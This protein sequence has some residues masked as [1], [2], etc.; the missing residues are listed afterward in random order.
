MTDIRKKIAFLTFGY[1]QDVPGSATRTA[2]DAH[3]QTLDLAQAAED[4][5]VDGAFLRVHHWARQL[6]SPFPLLA[7]IA[8][9]TRRI[10]IGT[11]VINMRYENPLYMAEE[12][13]AVDLISGGRLQLGISRGAPDSVSD[14]P[15]AFGY[16]PAGGE[17]EADMARRK[18]EQFLSAI[19]GRPV[20]AYGPDGTKNGAAAAIQPQ[21]PGLRQR[22]WWGSGSSA[23][24]FWAGKLGMNL[25][26]STVLIEDSGIPFEQLQAEQIRAYRG[27][28]AE[29]GQAHRP[30]VSVARTVLPVTED[31]DRR[32]FG[33]RGRGEQAG[34]LGNLRSLAGRTYV[35]APEVIAAD[36]ARD[37]AVQE[38][39]TLTLTLPSRLG[40]DYNA[41]ILQTIAAHIA[42]AIGW[43]P[44]PGP[45]REEGV[46]GEPKTGAHPSASVGR[47]I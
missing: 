37:E 20:V 42:P 46:E 25:Q 40:V 39:D 7:A 10:E 34:S 26:S 24:A 17:S 31:I 14:G 47:G 6:A 23:T 13:A 30:R 35:G 18:T 38:A 27:A 2:A 9:R 29:S 28:Y 12:A 8:A 32:Y 43:T 33:E 21:S 15:R 45:S 16:T 41:R 5:G 19:E 1:W 3:L 11:G 4:I 44:L 36:L 22:I